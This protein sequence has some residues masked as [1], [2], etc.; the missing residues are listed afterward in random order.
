[1]LRKQSTTAYPITFPMV[2]SADHYTAATGKTVSI[3]LQKNAGAP[4]GAAGAV[5]ELGSGWYSWAGNA[6]DR[7][8]L[9]DLA[10]SCSA[11]GCDTLLMNCLITSFDPF[12]LNEVW[13]H[14]LPNAATAEVALA[15][16]HST[17][18]S[19]T[20]GN[21]QLVRAVHPAHRLNID[22]TGGAWMSYPAMTIFGEILRR[23]LDLPRRV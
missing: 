3:S 9:G 23:Q 8:T 17:V 20:Y 10:I 5:T 4:V 16:A 6:T 22:P 1:M 14:V 18:T 11:A 15:A 13:T 19:T 7:N 12:S 2:L 21:A